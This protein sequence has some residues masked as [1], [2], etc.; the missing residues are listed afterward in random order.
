MD[1]RRVLRLRVN[2]VLNKL[3]DERANLARFTMGN[4][5]LGFILRECR[6]SVDVPEASRRYDQLEKEIDTRKA[7]L[8]QRINRVWA[9]AETH[10]VTI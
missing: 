1:A 10:G 2:F 9:F 5:R 3:G 6:N 8:D 4:S 7:T